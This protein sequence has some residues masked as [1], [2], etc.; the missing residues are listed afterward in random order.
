M[1]EGRGYTFD[2]KPET[3]FPP[4]YPIAIGLLYKIIGNLELAGHLV[5][6]ISWTGTIVVFFFFTRELYGTSKVT[7]L[8]TAFLASNGFLVRSSPMVMSES[9]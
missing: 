1:I 3:F 6:A 5:S 8:A 2:G 7:L 4:L 9:L